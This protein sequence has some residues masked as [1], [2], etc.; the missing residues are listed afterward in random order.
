VKL[1]SPLFLGFVLFGRFLLSRFQ[2]VLLARE[3]AVV[4]GLKG[5]KHLG[6]TQSTLQSAERRLAHFGR[7]LVAAEGGP[8]LVEIP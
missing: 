3:E 6:R 1:F 5:R 7:T 4:L 2:V 8:E